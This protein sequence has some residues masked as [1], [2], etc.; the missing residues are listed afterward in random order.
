[1]NKQYIVL[2]EKLL[3]CVRSKI[4]Q[5]LSKKNKPI[6]YHFLESFSPNLIRVILYNMMSF[7][8]C[9]KQNNDISI[10]DKSQEVTTIMLDQGLFLTCNSSESHVEIYNRKK[11]FFKSKITRPINNISNELSKK[12]K[13][14]NLLKQQFINYYDEII[15]Q[16][17]SGKEKSV[18]LKKMTII[19][20][21]FCTKFYCYEDDVKDILG[22]YRC[23]I[24]PKMRK[25]QK[26]DIQRL[27]KNRESN[28]HTMNL[29]NSYKFIYIRQTIQNDFKNL[30]VQKRLV[31]NSYTL[32]EAFDMLWQELFNDYEFKLGFKPYSHNDLINYPAEFYIF[33]VISKIYIMDKYSIKYYQY[34]KKGCY[35]IAIS[36]HNQL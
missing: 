30:F 36:L 3:N 32:D 2:F 6:I 19:Y 10:I 4:Y 33:V 24:L 34:I 13:L 22:Q 8:T 25:K 15:T 31:L 26:K 12:E 7:P 18:K 28:T 29:E 9:N 16:N 17:L 1:M 23:A 27:N 14:E 21:K 35:D 11:D 5:D 20:D